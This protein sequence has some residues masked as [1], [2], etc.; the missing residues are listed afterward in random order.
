LLVIDGRALSLN[1][2]VVPY[3]HNMSL[4]SDYALKL[5]TV[6]MPPGTSADSGQLLRKNVNIARHGRASTISL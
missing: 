5:G 4:F 2:R 3:D 1:D 6:W